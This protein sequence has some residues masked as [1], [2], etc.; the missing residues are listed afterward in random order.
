MSQEEK[1]I[2]TQTSDDQDIPKETS[3]RSASARKHHKKKKGGGGGSGDKKRSKPSTPKD[4][5]KSPAK[6]QKRDSGGKKSPKRKG[7]GSK[8]GSKKASRKGSTDSTGPVSRDNKPSI[9]CRQCEKKFKGQKQLEAHIKAKH[10]RV[11]CP[12]CH[13]TFINKETMKIHKKNKHEKAERRKSDLNHNA[14][15][16]VPSAKG[17]ARM[18]LD[19]NAPEFKST[20][21]S[22]N[23][24]SPGGGAGRRRKSPRRQT[25]SGEET[26]QARASG[27][28][29][30]KGG[31]PTRR[32]KD[33]PAPEEEK[34]D[35][36]MPYAGDSPERS[37]RPSRRLT[38]PKP[39]PK[40][41]EGIAPPIDYE[42]GKGWVVYWNPPTALEH[43]THNDAYVKSLREIADFQGVANFW[44]K[45]SNLQKPSKII[46]GAHNFMV[47]RKGVVPA[48]ETFPAGGAWI[49]NFHRWE[50]ETAKIDAVWETVMFGLAS[51]AFGTPE[52]VG[53]SL[54]IRTRG[55]RV[56]IWN[57]DNRVGDVRFTVADKLRMLLAI[58]PRKEV[59][60]KYF[61]NCLKD[62]STTSMAT[63]YQFVKV[64]F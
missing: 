1:T 51:E 25:R 21:S 9:I 47:F 31:A 53:A 57:R 12:T 33:D 64:T 55:Y 39:D 34:E 48:W 3:Q 7:S 8:S 32:L 19:S 38:L 10:P 29:F 54:H 43:D 14:P 13:K 61:S 30:G 5:K 6:K 16:F 11:E 45:I 63:P 20:R 46:H 44:S 23:T 24:Q 27:V 28:Q 49:I 50:D 58:H 59:K 18:S 17:S 62:G 35:G 52:V 37:K 4:T 22:I 56:C 26:K 40:D 36:K 15:E 2:D 41:L 42:I 60:Y